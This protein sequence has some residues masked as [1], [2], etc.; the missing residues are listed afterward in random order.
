M[1]E[2][3]QVNFIYE[4]WQHHAE[5]S[6]Y[7]MLVPEL[8]TGLPLIDY[9]DRR[10]RLLPWRLVNYF[11][12]PHAG[13]LH[14]SHHHFYAELSAAL[15]MVS[16]HRNIYHI[17]YGDWGYRHL[18]LLDGFNDNHV[19]ASFHIP[20]NGLTRFVHE[21]RYFSRLGAAVVVGKNQIPFFEQYLDRSKVHWIPHGV[22]TVFF[23]P[24]AEPSQNRNN[25]VLFVGQHLRDFDTLKKVI[26]YLEKDDPSVEVAL[27][28]PEER[29]VEFST[30]RSVKVFSRLSDVELLTLYRTSDLMLLPVLDA[31]AMNAILE[32]MACGLPVVATDVGGV[33][34]YVDDSCAI[35][36][37]PRD[38]ETMYAA[39]CEVLS[40]HERKREMRKNSRCKAMEFDWARVKSQMR[41]LYCKLID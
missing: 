5:H 12:G 35:L 9:Q 40:D 30:F 11:V 3:Q 14:Y 2:K 1:I 8:G 20:P 34:D 16:S 27:V 18:G 10:K 33:K 13:N 26:K 15:H 29:K 17:L 38:P 7:D 41:E 31:T 39:V 6:G 25:R 36:V 24:F 19:V 22:D 37:P 32:G 21:A 28:L 23:Q 4:R